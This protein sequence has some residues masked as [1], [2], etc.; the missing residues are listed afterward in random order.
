VCYSELLESVR[1][2]REVGRTVGRSIGSTDCECRFGLGR[3]AWV[4]RGEQR[5]RVEA[6][7]W[8][9]ERC[10]R[11]ECAVEPEVEMSS[12]VR[13]AEMDDSG[14]EGRA[15]D[16]IANEV[17]E[18]R[19]REANDDIDAKEAGPS[20]EDEGGWEA[21]GGGG[22]GRSGW[23]EGY[24]WCWECWECWECCECCECA[25]FRW[26]EEREDDDDGDDVGGTV[27]VEPAG[28]QCIN[29]EAAA[30]EE[31]ALK[32]DKDGTSGE[33]EECIGW[34]LEAKSNDQGQK[35]PRKGER[36]RERGRKK[37]KM[38]KKKKKKRR[39][40]QSKRIWKWLWTERELTEIFGWERERERKKKGW[41]SK[42]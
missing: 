13:G 41:R 1:E 39:D 14:H 26:T 16:V 30:A 27:N 31:E 11:R 20:D 28:G 22:G 35:R 36:E 18:S 19:G 42:E 21:E 4:G 12:E 23:W 34:A 3:P 6:G 24:G 7:M 2:V 25:G 17:D 5:A 38:K 9:E 37:G 10:G 29:K 40:K 33:E 32:E 8:F 15:T